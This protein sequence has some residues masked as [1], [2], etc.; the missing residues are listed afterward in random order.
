MSGQQ[1][2]LQAG[3][4]IGVEAADEITVL[5]AS[6]RMVKMW[7]ADGGISPY[8]EAKNFS[9]ESRRVTGIEEL[10]K[11]LVEL[12]GRPNACIIRGNFVGFEEAGKLETLE[13]ADKAF[14]RNSLY[15]D[16]PLHTILIEVDDFVPK[17]A[18]PLLE[19]NA[20]IEEY[21][22]TC[23]PPEFCCASYHWQLSNSAG[24][25]DKR[26][27]LMVHLW[28]WLHTPYTSGQLRAWATAIGLKSD[29]SV[30]QKIQCHYTGRPVFEPGV[31][32][33]LPEIGRA[34]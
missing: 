14:R 34:H 12:E 16:E 29:H 25:P 8:D 28:F 2:S 17:K 22:T 27:L 3:E 21:I 7:R 20:A 11:L 30:F 26:H 19:P 6:K 24:R 32:D 10:S 1:V 33:P 31:I 13:H 15:K 18:D 23:L 4:T 9:V 5:V